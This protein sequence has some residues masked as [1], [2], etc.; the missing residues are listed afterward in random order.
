MDRRFVIFIIVSAVILY[1]SNFMVMK[2][3]KKSAKNDQSV[4]N[5]EQIDQ[6]VPKKYKNEE[7]TAKNGLVEAS[8]ELVV[9]RTAV[10]IETYKNEMI[11]MTGTSN[12]AKLTKARVYRKG[13]EKEKNELIDVLERNEYLTMNTMLNGQNLRLDEKNWDL[14]TTDSGLQFEIEPVEN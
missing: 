14:R 8:Q 7:K 13:F 10:K 4:E 2:N 9:P 1:F 3:V 5:A 12:G 6:K 11:K